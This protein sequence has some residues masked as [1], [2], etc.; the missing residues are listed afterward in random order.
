MVRSIPAATLA[1]L[2]IDGAEPVT[3]IEVQWTED[4]SIY[5]YSDKDINSNIKGQIVNVSELDAVVQVQNNADSSQISVTLSDTDNAIHDIMDQNDIHKRPVWV[6]QWFDGL[7]LTDKVLVFKGQIS[8]PITWREG[9]RTVSFDVVTRIEDVQVGF[10]VEEGGFPIIGS[11]LIGKPWPIVFGAVQNA[12]ALRVRSGVRGFLKH[13]FGIIDPSLNPRI[14]QIQ[15]TCCPR[16]KLRDDPDP[17]NDEVTAI[18]GPDPNCE[19]R[20]LAELAGLQAEKAKQQSFSPTNIE[21]ENGEFFP[22]GRTLFLQVDDAQL[23]GTFSGDTF[24]T[25]QKRHPTLS[26][27]EFTLVPVKSF[28]CNDEVSEEPA[29]GN[30]VDEPTCILSQENPA[31]E[32]SSVSQESWQYYSTMPSGSF[33]WAEAGSEV[34]YSTSS[35]IVYVVSLIPSTVLA[36]RAWRRFASGE[37]RLVVVPESYYTVRDTDFGTYTVTEVVMERSLNLRGQGWEDEEIYTTVTSSIGPNTV[38]IL[39][40]FIDTYTSYSIDSTS[41]DAVRTSVDNY[42]MDFVLQDRRNIFTVLREIAFQARCAIF[43]RDD[44]FFLKYLP[45]EPAPADTIEEADIDVGSLVIGHTDTEDLVTK[46]IG[47]F[48]DDYSLTEPFEVI[49]SYNAA[50]YGVTTQTYDFYAYTRTDLVEKSV[51]FWLIRL[52]QTWRTI[53]FTTDLSELKLEVFDTIS[54]DISDFAPTTISGC[55]IEEARINSENLSIEFTAWTPTLAGTN[56]KYFAAFPADI[57]VA[58]NLSERG[59]TGANPNTEVTAPY[60]HVLNPDNTDAGGAGED[61]GTGLENEPQDPAQDPNPVISGLTDPCE[62]YN[63]LSNVSAFATCPSGS[64]PIRRSNKPLGCTAIDKFY[65]PDTQDPNNPSDGQDNQDYDGKDGSG[66]GPNNVNDQ[67]NAPQIQENPYTNERAEQEHRQEQ[68]NRKEEET[69]QNALDN[70]PDE[71]ELAANNICTQCVAVFF[72]RAL[73][74]FLDGGGTSDVPGTV[75]TTGASD[76]ENIGFEVVCFNSRIAAGDFAESFP[77]TDACSLLDEFGSCNIVN[78]WVVG[79]SYAYWAFFYKSFLWSLNC[80]GNGTEPPVDEQRIIGYDSTNDT[81]GE[82]TNELVAWA[83][84]HS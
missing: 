22:Q 58:V 43:L 54:I 41:F 29:V 6:Y 27:G 42:P 80:E 46:I 50:K 48:T 31:A 52:A 7:A 61:G 53:S 74:V 81:T 23:T 67:N 36:V 33:Y 13:G 3:I 35:E 38:N 11:E 78:E 1:K 39:E 19:C 69:Q 49:A 9:D 77:V 2:A 44:T 76:W 37:R 56:E 72:R 25:Q 59:Q 83:Q 10:S 63:Q 55:L 12:R 24:T 4:G 21:I 26:T 45:T 20:K 30:E 18:Y 64:R 66:G 84:K 15:K 62:E 51:V 34:Y 68:N 60:G 16:I 75:S 65:C 73:E 17:L 79:E 70:L 5:S 14:D 32:A 8:S 47:T 71:E 28:N 40:W 82:T 57:T